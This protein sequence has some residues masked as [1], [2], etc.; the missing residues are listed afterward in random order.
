MPRTPIT[1]SLWWLAG[2]LLLALA[3]G[4]DSPRDNPLDPT[5]T[6]PVELQ[7]VLDDTV[8]TATLAWTR[9]EGE[10]EFGEYWVLRNTDKS[11]EVDT[12]VRIT[13]QSQAGYTDTSLA[14]RIDYAYRVSI[15]NAGG[16]EVTSP[17]V[18]VRPL[19][20][21]PVEIETLDF[22]SRT[23]SATLTWTQYRGPRFSSYHV[24]RRSVEEAPRNV[25]D[26][27]EPGVTTLVDSN[28]IGNAV[29][30]Y[31]VVVVTT[32]GEEVASAETG[33][34][35][36]RLVDTWPLE[37]TDDSFV[38]L[39]ADE[40]GHV[41][42]A[43][44]TTPAQRLL[45]RQTNGRTLKSLERVP[46]ENLGN[47]ASRSFAAATDG[48]G[49][50]FATTNDGLGVFTSSDMD[51]Q[52]EAKLFSDAF[53]EIGDGPEQ[54]VRGSIGLIGGQYIYFD[55]VLS[56]SHSPGVLSICRSVT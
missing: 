35:I 46:S 23:A 8:G 29:Y 17:E 22:D 55:N 50:W 9:Y 36:H 3:C 6:P 25:A 19:A 41:V 18:R 4:H 48:A 1:P 49:T 5:L 45:F 13:A 33:G 30:L 37:V 7:V 34:A 54:E 39:Y 47:A 51:F 10:A 26:L 24:R 32:R 42:V 56:V 16:L 2:P 20:L 43:T 52:M 31:Q 38:R 21:P 14:P 53:P 44:H 40:D 15:V 11:T 12:L 27:G 28:L